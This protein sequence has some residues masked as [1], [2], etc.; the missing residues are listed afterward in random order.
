MRLKTL[1]LSLVI[2]IN[3]SGCSALDWMVYKIDIPQGNY[4][5]TKDVD[6]LRVNMTKE[7]VRFVLGP[8]MLIDTFDEDEWYYV[9]SFQEGQGELTRRDL[10]V[11]FHNGQLTQLRGDY[12]PNED[13]MTPLNLQ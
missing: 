10:I 11:S 9:Y 2:T 5:D 6:K 1:L 13:F 3:L 8:S 7:Q 4:V 12:E